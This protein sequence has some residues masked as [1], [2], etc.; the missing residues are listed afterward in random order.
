MKIKVSVGRC[1]KK[2]EYVSVRKRV[3]KQR[4]GKSFCSFN[5]RAAFKENHPNKNIGSSKFCSLRPKWRFLTV[6]KVTHSVCICCTHQYVVLLVD[7]MDWDLTYKD[8]IKLN[9]S[10]L[11][12]PL[13][14]ICD[15][16]DITIILKS[17]FLT[18]TSLVH[19][20]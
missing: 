9:L 12:F 5:L 17:I 16:I 4:H 10:C 7:V 8:L 15:D 18:G 1:L 20:I 13:R 3:H 19:L 14:F 2:K 11:V 6:S